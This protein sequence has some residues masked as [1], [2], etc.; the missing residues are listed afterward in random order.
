MALASLE[1]PEFGLIR[2]EGGKSATLNQVYSRIIREKDLL[3]DFISLRQ[4]KGLK[5]EYLAVEKVMRSKVKDIPN[6]KE[7]IR[8]GV[9]PDDLVNWKSEI[10]GLKRL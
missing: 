4:S 5:L 9:K 1:S 8:R 3:K 7:L 10:I 2:K 6:N